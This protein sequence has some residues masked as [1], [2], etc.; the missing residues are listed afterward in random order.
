MP[1]Q[2]RP[3]LLAVD[4]DPHVL[5]AVR[6]DLT[7]AYQDRYRVLASQSPVEGLRV[8]DVLRERN[9]E[10]ALLLVDQRMPE[11]SGI[12]FLD[13]SLS[14]FPSARRVLLTAYADTG[15]AIDAINRVRLDHYLVKPWEPPEERLYPVLDDLLDGWQRSYEPPYGG[16]RVVGHRFAPATHQVRDFLTRLHQ[17]FRFVDVERDAGPELAGL[18]LGRLP[19]VLLPDGTRLDRPSHADLVEVLGLGVESR[20][21]HYDVV[22]VGGGPAGLAA[23]VYSASEGL[24]TLLLEAYVPGGQAGTSSRIENYLGFPAGVTGAELTRRAVAQARRFGA[25]VMAPV[26]A[27]SLRAAGRGRVIA[28]SDGSEISG[29]TVLLATG[30]AYH[31][32]DAQG[33]ERF[34]GAGIYYGATSSET[35]SCA[36]QHV[37]I[38]GGANSAGQAALHFA[39]HAAS[40]RM[41]VRADCLDAGMSHYLVREIERAP[42]IHVHTGTRL[43]AADGADRLEQITLEDLR[44]G[45]RTTEAAEYVFTYIGARPRTDWLS[46]SVLRDDK[47]FVLTGPDL[48]LDRNAPVRWEQPREPLLLETSMPG[49]FAAGDVRSHSIKRIAA[50]VGEGAMAVALIHHYRAVC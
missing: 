33:A 2:P 11:M 43:V 45:R 22:I 30:L 1:E 27:V 7:R 10:P 39:E 14:R 44:T 40:V 16:I 47:G 36:D 21:P 48:L 19:A 8:L 6:R 13:R 41:V 37:W 49:V 23:A 34:E 26:S 32:L 28:L 15:V 25:E 9:E 42:N 17:P 46:R 38:I 24:S 5:R 3:T 18:D 4:D 31:R 35:T 50:G 12:E 20:R 29:G